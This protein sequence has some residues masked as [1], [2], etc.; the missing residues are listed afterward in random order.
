[1]YGCQGC[2]ALMLA[3]EKGSSACVAVLVAAGADVDAK[4]NKVTLYLA[5]TAII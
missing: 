5:H 2:N 3:C 4:D 1:M